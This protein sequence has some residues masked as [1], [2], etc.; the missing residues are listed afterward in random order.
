MN[1]IYSL[2]RADIHTLGLKQIVIL[3]FEYSFDYQTNILFTR[4]SGKKPEY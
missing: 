1:V 2:E 4:R 3:V